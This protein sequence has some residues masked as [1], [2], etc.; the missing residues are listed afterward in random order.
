MNTFWYHFFVQTSSELLLNLRSNRFTIAALFALWLG[1]VSLP[2]RSLHQTTFVWQQMAYSYTPLFAGTAAALGWSMNIVCF[3]LYLLI[4]SIAKDRRCTVGTLVYCSPTSAQCYVWS[5]F[6]AS[7][8]YLLILCGTTFV[9]ALGV[10]AWNGE[11]PFNMLAFIKPFVIVALPAAVFV[12]AFTLLCSAS[13]LLSHKWI[14]ALYP[15]VYIA[16][17]LWQAQMLYDASSLHIAQMLDCTGVVTLA[18]FY[19]KVGTGFEALSLFAFIGSEI[20]SSAP[21]AVLPDISLTTDVLLARSILMGASMLIVFCTGMFVRRSNTLTMTP[22][23]TPK[24]AWFGISTLFS[25]FTFRLAWNTTWN[26][27]RQRVQ[28]PTEEENP[29]GNTLGNALA[30]PHVSLSKPLWFATVIAEHRVLTRHNR[31][32]VLV[33]LCISLYAFTK[34]LA[35]VNFHLLPLWML[36][37]CI[38]LADLSTREWRHGTSNLMMTLPLFTKRFV[39]WKFLSA[40]HMALLLWL[41]FAVLYG[42]HGNIEQMA[43]TVIGIVWCASLAIASGT[44]LRSEKPFVYAITMLIVVSLLANHVTTVWIDIAA[45]RGLP[46]RERWQLLVGTF[47]VL[48]AAHIWLRKRPYHLV[49]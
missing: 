9:A 28:Q 45:W 18:L 5:K 8:I 24:Q 23:S 11:R 35:V 2:A 34:P 41:P 36:L 12:S 48:T 43:G 7:V 39:W 19:G 26:T 49:R 38:V 29:D 20:P 14:L 16:F 6:C 4:D 25:R 40:T 31:V 46:L 37:L 32:V 10:Y 30:A 27:T 15:I 47:V 3:G 21:N 42:I 1:A 33:M 44:M 13:R 22:A 17:I